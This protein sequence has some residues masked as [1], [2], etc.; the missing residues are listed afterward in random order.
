MRTSRIGR[1]AV[2]LAA[3]VGVVPAALAQAPEVPGPGKPAGTSDTAVSVAVPIGR[4]S[5]GREF[6]DGEPIYV[7]RTTVRAGMIIV[8][9]S[10]TPFPPVAPASEKPPVS[11][12][13]GG[14]AVLSSG[15]EPPGVEPST[16]KPNDQPTGW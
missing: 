7:R 3:V 2:G 1:M 13:N 9:V 10:A 8:E 15:G 11:R 6:A 16:G 4:V 14:P 5:V 12:S